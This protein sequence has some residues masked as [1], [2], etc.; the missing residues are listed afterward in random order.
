MLVP[1]PNN[2]SEKITLR[3]LLQ[4]AREKLTIGHN[5][6]KGGI[7]KLPFTN[8]RIEPGKLNLSLYGAYSRVKNRE[9][10]KLIVDNLAIQFPSIKEKGDKY[11]QAFIKE[12]SNIAKNLNKEKVSLS[13]Y[14]AAGTK[15]IKDLGE[16]FFKKS[17]SFQ[18]QALR[19]AGIRA[20]DNQKTIIKLNR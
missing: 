3:K 13:P 17:K 12:Q 9:L 6:A 19:V 11:E 8:L 18:K 14:R 5:D 10:R 16:D 2:P 1:D 20:T 4:D 7:A 15:V